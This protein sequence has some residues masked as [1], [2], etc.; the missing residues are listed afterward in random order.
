MYWNRWLRSAFAKISLLLLCAC[1]Q[2]APTPLP[3]DFNTD[4]RILRG[5]WAGESDAGI[6]LKLD[7][8]ASAPTSEGYT[9]D[10]T[11]Q[12]G[13]DLAVPFST[14]I[15]VDVP[16]TLNNTTVEAQ[17]SEPCGFLANADGANGEAWEL[18]GDLPQ[19]SPP[20]FDLEA[21]DW[22]NASGAIGYNVTMRK[23]TNTTVP[24]P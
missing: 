4:P 1:T 16:V 7:L 21:Y 12:F 10:G 3:L 9:F 23:Q 2:E 17:T 5:I 22:Q 18:C 19:G 8:K 13:D 15:F 11:F 6:T 24:K 20:R 14:A